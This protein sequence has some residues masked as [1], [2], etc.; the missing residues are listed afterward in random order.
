MLDLHR[1][2]EGSL[3]PET[4]WAFHQAQGQRLHASLGALRRALVVPAGECPGFMGFLSRFA[5]LR[6][7][8]GG[9]NEIERLAREA[10]EDAALDGVVH[11]ELRF[12]PIFLARR[13][14]DQPECDPFIAPPPP[15]DEIETVAEALV[16]GARGEAQRRNV[17]I[18]FILCLNRAGGMVLN[19]P[20]A[21]LLRRP[22]GAAIAAVDVAGDESLPLDELKPLLAEWREAGK[23]L[24]LHAG[25]D[26]RGDGSTRVREAVLLHGA[27]RIGHGIRAIEDAGTVSMLRERGTVLE[28]CLTSNVQTGAA[29]SYEAHPLKRLL[30]A[31]V[32]A[33]LNSDDPSISG[34]RLSDD[35]GWALTRAGLSRDDLR[36]A[37]LNAV[38]GAFL[39]NADRERLREQLGF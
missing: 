30:A 24:T 5:A 35:H 10:V 3:R 8:Y 32:R 16:R 34:I 4:L 27:T 6:F 7:R 28:T 13:L 15:S 22:V 26:P 25:E 18:A 23:A 29:A 37:T 9:L 31:G 17:S 2:L 14:H 19:Q 21:D 39:A 33:T 12:S 38:D 11:L 1:H 20:A 36:Q